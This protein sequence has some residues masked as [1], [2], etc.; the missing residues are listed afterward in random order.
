MILFL[1]LPLSIAS[2]WTVP[3]VVPSVSLSLVC[4]EHES[5]FS[6]FFFRVVVPEPCPSSPRI[7]NH[8]FNR[9]LF[10]LTPSLSPS[11]HTE[12][13]NSSCHPY[14]VQ[15]HSPSYDDDLVFLF[16]SNIVRAA[17]CNRSEERR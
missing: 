15:P 12:K 6:R 7:F 10:S 8:Y 9:F 3:F 2:T 14:P 13:K 4:Y 5:R 16:F 17:F 1:F 11:P